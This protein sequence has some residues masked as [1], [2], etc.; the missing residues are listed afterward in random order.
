MTNFIP[1]V[2]SIAGFDPSG[3]AGILADTKTA[4]SLNCYCFGVLSA[5]TIQNEDTFLSVHWIPVNEIVSQI[6]I[7]KQYKTS[8]KAVKIGIIENLLV[9]N[10]IVNQILQLFPHVTII[11]DPI[12]KA[13]AGF[14]FH[15]DIDKTL[16]YNM[17][18]KIDYITP[19]IPE[20]TLLWNETSA[21]AIFKQIQDFKNLTIIL[22]GGHET[23]DLAT[24]TIIT[25]NEIAEITKP[26][27]AG[28]NKHGTGCIFSSALAS[29]IALELS[30]FEAVRRAGDYTSLAI[31]SNSSLL[32]YHPANYHNEPINHIKE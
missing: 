24:D 16:F 23:S 32:A 30:K 14:N 26:R 1:S 17:L 10:E 7:L 21:Q 20:A 27:I 5:N 9:L 29:F 12:L 18:K 8:I 13:S 11:W 6:Q 31:Q 15:T 19:N 22:K 25:W 28:Y 4:Q 3:G 2:L